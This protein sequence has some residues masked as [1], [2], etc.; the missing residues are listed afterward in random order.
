MPRRS[1]IL[2]TLIEDCPVLSGT[3]TTTTVLT[4]PLAEL[5]TVIFYLV[6]L[7]IS[8]LLFLLITFELA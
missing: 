6:F 5:V 3:T 4:F 1:K 7:L 8:Q 2:L